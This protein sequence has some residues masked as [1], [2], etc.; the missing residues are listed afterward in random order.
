MSPK[1]LPLLWGGPFYIIRHYETV[2]KTQFRLLLCSLNRYPPIIVFN[3]IRILKVEVQKYC[4]I[5]EF[6]LLFLNYF[7]FD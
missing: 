5:S 4:A 7:G 6:L 2:Q 1:G 3:T